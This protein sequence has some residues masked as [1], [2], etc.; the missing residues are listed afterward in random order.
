MNFEKELEEA[1]FPL[2]AYISTLSGS[3]QEA[4][5]ILGEVNLALIRQKSS[6]DSSRPFLPW[7][8]AI[9][10]YAVK[11]WRTH[12]RR[13]PVLFDSDLLATL[14]AESPDPSA[15]LRRELSWERRRAALEAA[16]KELAPEMRDLLASHYRAGES[17]AEIG[18]RLNRTPHSIAV[19]LLY[20][21]KLLKRS[22]EKKLG[23]ETDDQPHS[24]H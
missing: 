7:A 18:R 24:K 10:W 9:A 22:I 19:S 8:R 6:Y 21:R 12:A 3:P 20:I 5:D 13:T 17:L 4:A 14:D 15:S 23:K 2:L 16:E 1:Q 11:T